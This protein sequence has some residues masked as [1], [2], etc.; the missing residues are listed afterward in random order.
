MP[1]PAEID[2]ALARLESWF[3]SCPGTLV[4][5]SGGVDSSLVAWLAKHFLGTERCLAVISA[6]PSLKMSE[7][8]GG[9]TFAMKQGIPLEVIV[10]R[11]MENPNYTSNPNNRC[12]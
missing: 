5:F 3:Q 8:E 4:A 1:S 11:E 6:S 9:R 7:L 10:T 2:S 12:Y